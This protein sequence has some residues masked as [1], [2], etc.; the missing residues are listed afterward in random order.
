MRQLTSGLNFPE[1]PVALGDG[2]LLVGEIASGT[3]ARVAADGAVTRIADCGGG[4]NGMAIGP[5]ATAYVCNNGGLRFEDF[6]DHIGPVA[7][8]DERIGGRIQRVDV[9][10]GSVEAVYT[11]F[12]GA[13]LVSPN[14]LVFDD[15][16]WFYFTDT[17]SGC[18]YYAAADGSGIARVASDL[19]FPNG[20]GLSPDGEHVYVAE[21]YSG[22]VWRLTLVKPGIVAED[23]RQ[24]LCHLEGGQFDSLAID[25]EGNVCVATLTANGVTAIGPDGRVVAEVRVPVKDPFVTNICFGGDDLRTAYITSSGTGRVFVTEWHCPGLATAYRR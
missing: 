4:V 14:D 5:D 17:A 24:L 25:S 20:V 22:R 21:T 10:T 13:E 16:G 18:L 1:G 9:D 15:R 6:G 3:I 2:T 11:E 19:T 7:L 23:G 8:A 12:D